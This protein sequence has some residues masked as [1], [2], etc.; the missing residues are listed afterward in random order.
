MEVGDNLLLNWARLKVIIQSQRVR[1]N[2]GLRDKRFPSQISGP[3][4]TLNMMHSRIY[5]FL[6]ATLTFG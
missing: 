4:D 5:I 6:V 2:E 1:T 3:F